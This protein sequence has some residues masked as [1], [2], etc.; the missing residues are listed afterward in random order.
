[1]T[2]ANEQTERAIV[3]ECELADAPEKVWRALT[4]PELLAA[5]LMPNDFQ[6]ELG[7]E[8]TFQPPPEL[9]L[10]APIACKVLAIEPPEHLRFSWRE[11]GASEA[12]SLSFTLTRSARGGTL[13]R[14]VQRGAAES[15]QLGELLRF[16][17]ASRA[18]SNAPESLRC[19]A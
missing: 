3:L 4:E 17:G 16:P 18:G 7:A 5:W 15:G 10:E 12:G 2:Q 19:A 6:P 9:G 8:F 13:L 1:M 11:S 14:L